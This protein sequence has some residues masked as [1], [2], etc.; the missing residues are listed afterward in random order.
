MTSAA[1]RATFRDP[2]GS[3]SFEDGQVIRRIDFAARAAV[4]DLLESPFCTAMQQTG[5]LIAA[6]IDDSSGVL[7]LRHPKIAVPTYPWEWTPSQWLAAAEL[8][9]DLCEQ[10]LAGG[11]MLK[12]ATPLNVLFVGSRPIFVDILSFERRD[13][14][15]SIWLAYG[16]YIRT[17][18]LPL[19]MQR[20]LSWPLAL[21]LFRRDGYEPAE[22][23]A[24]LGWTR[25]LGRDAFWPITLPALLDRRKADAVTAKK[26]PARVAD[27]QITA[28]VLRRTLNDLRERTRRALAGSAAAESEWSRYQGTLTHYTAEESREKLDWV[29]DALRDVRP[30][31][32]LD[33][34]ANTGEVSALAATMGADVVALERDMA[35]ADR[36]FRMAR[37]RK[38]PI[39]MIHADLARPTPAAGWENVESMTLL[40]RLEGQFDLVMMLAVIHHLVLME[41]IPLRAIVELCERL[42]LRYLIVEWIPV[43]DPMFQS[44]M[45]GRDA[46][47]GALREDDLLAAC[48]GRFEVMRRLVLGNG[49]VLFLLEKIG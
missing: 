11:W 32:V 17:F 49:R 2:A 6:E 9:L 25:R 1:P 3:L 5:D 13:K 48:D 29:R 41:Q 37:D 30:A 19:L 39:D 34:G 18:L 7:C 38:L 35:S 4:L 15:S 36:I 45:R 10:A 40:D 20:M 47:Y 23:Y 24:A 8:T 14:H 28:S 27:P 12:D 42:T 26:R 22:C 44:L 31:R 16:Q 33:I 46:L 43:S 21:S